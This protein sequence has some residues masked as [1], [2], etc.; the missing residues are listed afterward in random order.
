MVGN[1]F[2]LQKEP[3][4]AVRFFERAIQIDPFFTYAYTL[5]GHEHVNSENIEK[6]ITLFRQALLHNPRHY[7]AWY[8][9]GSIYYRQ[10]RFELSE[11]HFR[12][13]HEINSNSSVLDCYLAMALYAQGSDEKTSDALKV[14]SKAIDRDPNNPQVKFPIFLS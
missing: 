2:S 5:S 11:Y 13:A 8:G 10:E 7:N 9:L 4:T 14:L 3:E 12:K 1:C 6:A